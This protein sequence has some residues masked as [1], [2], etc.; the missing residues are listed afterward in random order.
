MLNQ[1]FDLHQSLSQMIRH[2]TINP[3][4]F[5]LYNVTANAFGSNTFERE[6]TK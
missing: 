2:T 4:F 5:V 1:L 3:L 6:P